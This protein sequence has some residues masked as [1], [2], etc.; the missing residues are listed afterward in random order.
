MRIYP[1]V[2]PSVWQ[3]IKFQEHDDDEQYK[4]ISSVFI[5]LD[6][7]RHPVNNKN[8]GAIYLLSYINNLDTF[9]FT[10]AHERCIYIK[11]LGDLEYKNKKVISSTHGSKEHIIIKCKFWEGLINENRFK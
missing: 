2:W 4:K 11:G 5:E 8:G 9:A 1:S 3:D 6:G 7:I 10:H